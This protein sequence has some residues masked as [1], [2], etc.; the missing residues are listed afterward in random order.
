MVNGAQLLNIFYAIPL[1]TAH[2][3]LVIGNVA[4]IVPCNAH[5]ALIIILFI[6]TI[7]TISFQVPSI[8]MLILVL[9]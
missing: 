2:S 3:R 8:L 1:Q 6:D 7:S 9:Q 5:A 4:L